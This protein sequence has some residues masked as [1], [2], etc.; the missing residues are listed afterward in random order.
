CAFAEGP[1]T[2]AMLAMIRDIEFITQNSSLG[3][4][5]ED[6]PEVTIV[7]AIELQM[8]FRSTEAEGS[9]ALVSALYDRSMNKIYLADV[10]SIA[11][12]G[13]FHELVHF[14]QDING[15]NEMFTFRR[16]CL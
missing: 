5:G 1:E 12:P 9:A 6:L 13:L 7:S 15:K 4:A 14:L 16:A 3:Y 10:N 2:Q 11:G 8:R